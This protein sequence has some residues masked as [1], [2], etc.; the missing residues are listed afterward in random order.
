[1]AMG[2]AFKIS[3]ESR[4]VNLT[5][6]K[7][8]FATSHSHTNYYIDVTPQKTNLQEAKATAKVLAGEYKATTMVDT[9][10]CMDG[11]EVL[12]A[13]LANE[14]ARNDSFSVNAGNPISILTPEYT[15]GSQLFF[16]DNI[17]PMIKGKNVLLLA[18]SVVTGYSAK[19][20]AEAVNYYGGNVVGVASI[21]ATMDE[22]LGIPVK[23]VFNPNDLP[24]YSTASS[25]ECPLCK[26]GKKIDALVNSYG[27]SALR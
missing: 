27:C 7:G 10:L 11:T 24:D 15:Q 9:I 12:G 17:E 2:P 3:T 8:H 19:S 13:F 22:T 23:S 4:L 14:L 25:F 1:M 18:I 16:R 20:A 6:H 21:F 26:Q 5:I